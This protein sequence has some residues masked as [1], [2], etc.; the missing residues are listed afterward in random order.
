MGIQD[1]SQWN[2]VDGKY[3]KIMLLTYGYGVSSGVQSHA[4]MCWMDCS[5]SRLPLFCTATHESLMTEAGTVSG[6]S[7]TNSTLT[8]LIADFVAKILTI[9]IPTKHVIVLDYYWCSGCAA[10]VSLSRKW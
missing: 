5:R 3:N 9:S 7:D 1:S 8:W 4:L 2:K 10:D 6:T